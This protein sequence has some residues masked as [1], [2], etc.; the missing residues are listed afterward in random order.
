MSVRLLIGDCR[1]TLAT[2]PERSVQSVA[3]SPPYWGLRDYGTPPLVWGGDPAHAHVWGPAHTAGWH[4]GTKAGIATSTLN[5]SAATHQAN[6]KVTGATMGSTCACGAWLGSLGLE[7]TPDLYVEHIVE[8][9]RPVRRVL[10]DDGTLWLNLGDSYAGS[11]KGPTGH[12]GFQNAETR[13]GFDSG[14]MMA[15]GVMSRGGH[16]SKTDAPAGYKAKDLLMI[17]FR[18]AMALQADGWWLRSVI[19]WLKRNSMPES[20][21]D[22]PATAVEYVFLLSKSAR[23][24]WNADAVRMPPVSEEQR[25]HNERYAKV[26]DNHTSGAAAN[27]QP[28]NV[29]NIGI[30]SRPGPGGRNR[31]NSDWFF[32]SW[33]GLLLDEQDDPLAFVVNPAPFKNAH[34]ATFTPKL[35]EPMIKASTS[36]RGQCPECGAPWVRTV[37]MTPEYREL[38][39][40]GTAWR[41]NEGKPD[42]YTNRH[43]RG[44]PSQVPT[45]NTTTG[46]RASCAHPEASPV[47]QTVLDCFAGAATTLLVADRLGRNAIGCELKPEYSQMGDE[48]LRNDAPMFFDGVVSGVETGM[49]PTSESFEVGG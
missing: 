29:N 28:N 45:K 34:Y 49:P 1:E 40:S 39:D 15:N 41:T 14:Y 43:Q 17:P 16:K 42:E 26:Y 7:P 25:I 31:R 20:V 6:S 19:P 13:Q 4:V 33:Q 47:P 21:T 3:T 9:F 30:H 18:V 36:E 2:L 23:Y 37:E 35:V 5:N 8:C 46:W 10:R 27:G 11:G 32:E 38:L 12:N 44:H 48:R 22:R 24:F